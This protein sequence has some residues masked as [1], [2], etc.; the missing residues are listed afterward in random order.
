MLVEVPISV[1]VP[2]NN[3]EKDMGISNLAGLIL[4][5]LQTSKATGINIAT[6][7][8]SLINAERTA[9]VTQRETRARK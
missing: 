9:E 1:Q 2:P 4:A 3:A 6:T 8:E 5:S 7:A